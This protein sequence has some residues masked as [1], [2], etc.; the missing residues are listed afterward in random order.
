MSATQTNLVDKSHCVH[1]QLGVRYFQ[2]G[3]NTHH[4]LT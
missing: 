1:K 2:L 4:V 3:E